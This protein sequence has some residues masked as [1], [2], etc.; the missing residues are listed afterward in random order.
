MKRIVFKKLVTIALSGLLVL[1][2]AGCSSTTPTP[3]TSGAT[4]APSTSATTAPTGKVIKVL[5]STSVEPLAVSLGDAYKA[6]TGI[7][8]EIQAPGSSQGIQA[9]IDGTTEIGTSSRE[10]TP[11]EAATKDLKQ[12]VIAIDGIVL[13]VNPENTASVKGLTKQQATDIF[14]GKITN[15]KDVGGLDKQIAV[16][17]REESSGTRTA[18]QEL[19]GLEIKNA[20]GTKTSLLTKE[21]LTAGS[22]GEV[23]TTVATNTDA[24]GYVSLATVDNTVAGL[25]IDGVQPT[26]DNIKADK[27]ILKR[28]FLMLTKNPSADVK[29][30]IDFVLSPEG[31][32]LVEKDKYIKVK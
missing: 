22:Q 4:T 8:L 2:F 26:V 5:G 31:Q 21:G 27:Y 17:N 20:D 13:I 28:N 25:S 12:N 11:E 24:I 32:A 1:A 16:I 3:S 30:F 7:S 19:L 23:K 29:A 10:L 18:I 9:I 6:K 15:W 14:S